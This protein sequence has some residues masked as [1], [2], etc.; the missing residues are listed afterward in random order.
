MNYSPKASYSLSG[1]C[2]FNVWYLFYGHLARYIKLWV[3][4]VL[5]MPGIFSLLPNSKETAS[6]R[7]HHASWH[8][9]HAHAVIHFGIADPW[10]QGKHSWHSRR[11]CNPQFCISGKRPMMQLS[12]FRQFCIVNDHAKT[13]DDV[14]WKCF[15]VTAPLWWEFHVAFDVCL[16]KHLK[17]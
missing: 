11:M 13:N 4:H 6:K 12:W 3:A 16:N 5:G 2:E 9:R 1:F 14:I 10:W 7:S 15:I 8:V 17:K